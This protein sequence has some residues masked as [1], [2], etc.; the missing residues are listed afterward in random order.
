MTSDDTL[1]TKTRRDRRRG[2]RP[3]SRSDSAVARLSRLIWP[4]RSLVTNREVA[5]PGP[6]EPDAWSRLQFVTGPVCARC[7]MLFEIAVDDDQ[8]CAACI[9]DPPAYDRA[10]SALIYGDVSREIILALKHQ[11]RRDGLALMAGWMAQAAPDLL[12]EADL[13]VPVPLHYTRLIRRGFNQSVWLGSAL[14]RLGAAPVA[15][16]A[17]VRIRATP[18]QGGLT[19]VGRQRNVAGAFR[20]RKG[21]AARLKGRRILLVDDVLTTGA[22][23]EACAR[24]LKKGGAACVDVLT[25]ARVAGPRSIPI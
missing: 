21:N 22:T 11:G 19:A 24:A 23:A 6:L 18:I 7:G 17:L 13:I 10:R 8:V 14:R 2:R 4:P 9:A 25:L 3:S 20:V 12:A 16:D 15:V 5:G 1:A